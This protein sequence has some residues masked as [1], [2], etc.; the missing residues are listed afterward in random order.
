M[1][2]GLLIVPAALLVAGVLHA[3]SPSRGPR[4]YADDPLVAEPAPLPVT[5]LQHRA[6][7]AVLETVNSN[8]RSRGQ[9]HPAGGVIPADGVNSLG[10]VMD[11]DWYVNRHASHRMTIAEL[12][13]GSGTDRAPDASK[14]WQVLIVKPFGVN[15]GILIADAKN[16]LYILRFDLRGHLGLETGAQMVT[17]HFFHALGYYVGENYIVGF[18]RSRLVAHEQGEAVSSGGRRRAL[19]AD[20]IERFLRNV[21]EVA[22]KTYRAVATRLPEARE[23]LL[24]PYQA[25]GSRS[26]DPNDIVL[27]EHRRDL[28][29]MHVFAAWLNFTGARAVTT[30]DIV[31][32]AGGVER[33]RHFVVDFTKSLGSGA[34]DGAKLAWEGND[35]IL[36]P[37]REI[38]HNIAGLGLVTPAWMKEKHPDLEEVGA[39]GSDAFDPEAWTPTDP[40]VP[41]INRLP[42]DTFW[43]AK[44]VVAFTDEEIRALVQTGQ[45]SKTAEDWITNA[46]VERRDRIGR[47]YFSRV[48]PLDR[49]RLEGNTLAFDDLGVIRGVS[50]PRTYVIEWHTFDNAKDALSDVIGSGPDIPPVAQALPPGSYVAAHIHAGAASMSVTAYLRRDAGTFRVIGLD[51]SW[52]GKIVAYPP[53]PPHADR[54][55][56]S[57]LAPRQQELFATY[58]T[59]YNEARGTRFTPEEVFARLTISEQTTFYGHTHALLNSDLTDA[60]GASLGKAIDRVASVERI[61]G[62]YAGKGGDEQFR[63]YVTLKPDTQEVIEKS[64]EFFRDHENTVYH[65]GFPHSFRQTGKPPTLQFSVSNDWLGADIDVDYRS[66]KSPKALFNGH[67]TA[68]NSDVRAGENPKL[69]SARWS[70]LVPWWQQLFGS[71]KDSSASTADVLNLQRPDAAPTPLPPD[72]PKGASPEKIEDAS[73]EFLTDWLVRH[74]YDQALEFLSPQAFACLNLNEDARGQALDAAGSRRELL[75]IMEL[76]GRT[77]GVRPDLTSAIAAIPPRNPNRPVTD[78]AFKREFLLGPVPETEARQYLCSQSTAPLAGTQYY[79]VLFQFRIEGGGVLGLLWARENGKW[80]IVSYQ[81]I[82]Q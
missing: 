26:D 20:D 72:R 30:Q 34:F 23:A 68:A 55:V 62:Q 13:R 15:P 77:I 24:G 59:R 50:P 31:T 40:M 8:L 70:G 35:T 45:Y 48:L 29:G 69:H 67:L 3:Q 51:R 25:W 65:I 43:A 42:D 1:T 5:G 75:R 46:L 57:D 2:R 74:Q 10:E 56:Y 66:D 4:F 37:A 61:A 80:K 18:D 76:A 81:P 63:L 28:R 38:G 78:H 7:S 21:P 49:I 19:E 52:P 54:R 14:P 58:T 39:F 11:G 82:E 71:L 47:V 44:Q 73:Q 9:R 27:H 16:D 22:G 12:Q 79:G 17:S 6:L 60:N 36:P 32:T 64:R 41:F 53:P 33:I